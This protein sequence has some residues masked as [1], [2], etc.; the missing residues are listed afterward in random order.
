M[1]LAPGMLPGR[2]SL[3]DGRAAFGA[4]WPGL[5]SERGKGTVEMLRAAAAGE[6]EVLVAL[7]ADL[8]DAPDSDLARRALSATT[9]IAVDLF[10]TDTTGLADIVLPA[11]A[12]SETHGTT[13]NI[14][15]RVSGV[16]QR[17]NAPGTARADWMIAAELAWRLESD[18]GL[19]GPAQIWDEI[20]R[21]APSH[22]GV[23][24]L[25]LRSPKAADGVVVPLADPE[26]YLADITHPVTIVGS[27]VHGRAVVDADEHVADG[28]AEGATDATDAP[29]EPAGS[30]LVTFVAPSAT[31]QPEPVDAYSLRLVATRKLYDQ[32][33]LVQHSPSLAGLAAGTRVAI[34]SYDL[35]RL[36]VDDDDQVRISSAKATFLC[37]VVRDEGVPRGC[38]A[39]AFNQANV[40]VG[41]LIDA[42]AV[43]NDVR[44]ETV[45]GE[46]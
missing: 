6:I 5:P 38:A 14:E 17:A 43:V 4:A 33:T 11:A 10:E 44:V 28:D 15:G 32:G 26:V 1:G 3:E 40:A 12:F 39:M 24:S 13:T 18:L 36:G 2:V 20:E 9:V 19:E 8:L 21:L 41:E 30:P 29:G 27:T 34:N 42:G 45:G 35:D 16:T 31:T 7:G 22:R 37:E 46:S 25:V 23:T